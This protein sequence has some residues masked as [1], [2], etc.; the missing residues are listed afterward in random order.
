MATDELS[1]R[2]NVSGQKNV[3]GVLDYA[4][5]RVLVEH[6][7]EDILDFAAERAQ[8]HAPEWTGNLKRN[9]FAGEI[10]KRGFMYTGNVSI[11]PG[12]PYA[13]WVESGTGIYGPFKIPIVPKT[14]KWLAWRGRYTGLMHH[15]RAVKG[16]RGQHFMRDSVLETRRI[17]VPMRLK[18]LG[19]QIKQAT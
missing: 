3:Y 13:K 12:A 1:V 19:E 8:G 15:A 17:Y 4:K 9:I 11:A 5:K 6:A 7:L 14:K 10:V 2:I 18:L 16:Q